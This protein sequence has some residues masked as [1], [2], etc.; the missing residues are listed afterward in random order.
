MLEN[1]PLCVLGDSWGEEGLAHRVRHRCGSRSQL[2]GNE[3]EKGSPGE[4]DYES[5]SSAEKGAKKKEGTEVY[6]T[7]P[8]FRIRLAKCHAKET[9]GRLLHGERRE[10]YLR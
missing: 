5:A 7:F 9:G 10:F 3:G 6:G 2:K 8:R 1:N 4:G